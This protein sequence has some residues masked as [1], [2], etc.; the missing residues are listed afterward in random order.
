VKSPPDLGS[1]EARTWSRD[2]DDRAE[3]TLGNRGP[4]RFTRRQ[5]LHQSTDGDARQWAANTETI[6]DLNVTDEQI[7]SLVEARRVVGIADSGIAEH[8]GASRAPT[9]RTCPPSS[10]APIRC[11]ADHT[12]TH[13]AR[14]G[15]ALDCLRGRLPVIVWPGSNSYCSTFP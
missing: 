4:A 7:L 2:N 3:A 12:L 1:R 13:R 6:D 5:P 8:M 14:R 9:L 11:C 10:T 15:D